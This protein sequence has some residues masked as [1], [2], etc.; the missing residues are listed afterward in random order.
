LLNRTN[1][2]DFQNP[3]QVWRSILDKIL[4]L[5]SYCEPRGLGITEILGHTSVWDMNRPLITTPSRALGYK[6]AA[7]ES[8][9]IMDGRNDLESIGPYSKAVSR[10]SDDG[11]V[12]FG[13]YGPWVIRQLRYIVDT[14]FM[15]KDSRQ[16]TMSIWQQN[17]GF[18]KDIPCTLTL[19]WF[20]RE[21]KLHCMANMRSSDAWLGVPYDVVNFS[22][23]S[24]GILSE[25][26]FKYPD[27]ELGK[28]VLNAGSQHIY[29]TN[30]RA[31][32][33]AVDDIDTLF[34][35]LPY[36]RADQ[37]VSWVGTV[38]HLRGL[39]D[40]EAGVDTWLS[41]I[42]TYYRQKDEKNGET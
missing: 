20:I 32:R 14:L 25:L 33:I 22:N 24:I 30:Y 41:E 2:N 31:A 37:L 21:E 29:D 4:T 35:Y 27:L 40:L 36:G 8:W 34:S 13:A 39:K 17:P 7:A 9:W 19:Q 26:R 42:I 10:F 23:I 28:L 11:E 38:D 16:A 15:D 3:N 5:G 6:F 1:V 18:S 12:F